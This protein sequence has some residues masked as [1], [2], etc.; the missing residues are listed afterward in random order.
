[1]R[2]TRQRKHRRQNHVQPLKVGMFGCVPHLNAVEAIRSHSSTLVAKL[3]FAHAEIIM[4]LAALMQLPYSDEQVPVAET[5]IYDDNPWRGT[6]V[7][8]YAANIQWD[9]YINAQGDYV[10]RMLYNER[11]QRFKAT[12][13]VS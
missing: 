8:P 7:T 2:H 6:L 13:K 11:Q 12:C 3:R 10:V 5:Y 1:M 9:V 4:P